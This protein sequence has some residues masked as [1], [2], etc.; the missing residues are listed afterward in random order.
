MTVLAWIVFGFI[1]GVITH[2]IDPVESWGGILGTI[3]LGVV[4][5]LIGGFL[6]NITLGL[7]ISGFNLESFIIA[8]L[9]ALLL[10]FIQRSFRRV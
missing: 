3:I 6:A 8:T 7:G 2:L 4:G 9:G 10:L 5:S 1:V